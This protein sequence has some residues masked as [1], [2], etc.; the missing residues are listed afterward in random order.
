MFWGSFIGSNRNWALINFTTGIC[1][2]ESCGK[3]EASQDRFGHPHRNSWLFLRSCRSDT[4]APAFLSS[5]P[6]FI[7]PLLEEGVW[8]A[9]L[10]IKG[11][12]SG[13]ELEFD[14]E[15]ITK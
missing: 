15:Q 6:L 11:K 13:I 5:L 1:W 3:T 2:K 7:F 4:M 10:G 8:L 9:R 14:L 12:R